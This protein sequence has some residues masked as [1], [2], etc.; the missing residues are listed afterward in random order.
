MFQF[1]V[2]TW[3]VKPAIRELEELPTELFG[4]PR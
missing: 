1:A 2:L 4:V 3:K